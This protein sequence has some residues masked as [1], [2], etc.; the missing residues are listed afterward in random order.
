MPYTIRAHQDGLPVSTTRFHAAS[1]VVL[2]MKWAEEGCQAIVIVDD[3]GRPRSLEEA[4]RD[5]T[6]RLRPRVQVLD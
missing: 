2:A 5:S 6:R 3:E 4:R 1:A